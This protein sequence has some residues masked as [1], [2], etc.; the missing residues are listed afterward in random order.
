MAETTVKVNGTDV[1][2]SNIPEGYQYAFQPK[3][4]EEIK[5]I[6]EEPSSANGFG[7]YTQLQNAQTLA[8]SQPKLIARTD[9]ATSPAKIT[10]TV[11]TKAF[12]GTSVT[13]QV[14]GI[15]VDPSATMSAGNYQNITA[16]NAA[17]RRLLRKNGGQ[18]IGRNGQVYTIGAGT[19]RAEMRRAVN[20]QR[21]DL[22]EYNRLKGLGLADESNDVFEAYSKNPTAS[23]IRYNPEGFKKQQS[24]QSGGTATPSSYKYSFS[25]G[26]NADNGIGNLYMQLVNGMTPEQLSTYANNGIIN[27]DSMIRYIREA[28]GISD[29]N[30]TDFTADNMTALNTKLN[31][32]YTWTPSTGGTTTP[33]A[34]TVKTPETTPTNSWTGT[35]SGDQFTEERL[36][37]WAALV[38]RVQEDPT[39]L[40]NIPTNK[41]GGKMNKFQFG[42]AVNQQ[43]V[44][45]EQAQAQQ[46]QLT[47][48]F[49]AIAQKPK[50]T[51][52]AL[53]KQGIQPKQIID[54]AQKMSDKNPAAKAALQALSQMQQMAKEGA[55][56]QYIKRL[57]GEC[58]EGYELKMFKA[59]GKVCTKCEK[60]KEEKKGG[61]VNG[62]E[63]ELVREFKSK[64]CKGGK[65]KK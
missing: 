50:E 27:N 15:S 65:M 53:Q 14:G 25:G 26:L 23:Y 29:F 30:G 35:I 20:Q 1:N 17:Q 9:V 39:I 16:L 54:L 48:I 13:P 40:D 41:R 5:L 31:T 59:G 45:Q 58:P 22:A 57:R 12:T 60:I 19:S 43:Q 55:K 21:R 10:P 28:G 7:I 4:K 46:Q 34:T 33:A 49:Q 36:K 24:Q 62:G 63:T 2:T 61:Q 52:M 42:G 64:R 11:K 37:K 6:T 8:E 44:A 32:K 56:L 18:Y 47:E 3:K 51:L 38:T